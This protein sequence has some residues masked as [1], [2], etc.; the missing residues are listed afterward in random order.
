M[1]SINEWLEDISRVATTTPP[2]QLEL[3]NDPIVL[4][5][6][7]YRSHKFGISPKWQDFN[8]CKITPEDVELSH[9]IKRYYRDKIMLRRL[10]TDTSLT[11]FQTRLYEILSGSTIYNTD[12]GLLYRLPY[13]YE[14]DRQL[15]IV[16]TTSTSLTVPDR[17]QHHATIKQTKLVR[18]TVKVYQGRHSNEICQYWWTDESNHAVVLNVKLNNTLLELIDSLFSKTAVSFHGNY[19]VKLM[20]QYQFIHYQLE[21][22]GINYVL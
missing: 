17:T 2:A 16:R 8:T 1:N 14:E 19:Y 18:P 15:D 22:P 21:S 9:L 12:L 5:C 10:K 7:A 11:K 6:S 20:R 13:F 3:N 4:S